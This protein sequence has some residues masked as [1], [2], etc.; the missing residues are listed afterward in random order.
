VLGFTKEES[1]ITLI[2]AGAALFGSLFG[3]MLGLWATYAK[4]AEDKTVQIQ[5]DR[6]RAYTQLKGQQAELLMILQQLMLAHDKG[7]FYQARAAQWM[8]E[9]HKG[10]EKKWTDQTVAIYT[11]NAQEQERSTEHHFD[12]LVACS[13]KMFESI[14]LI[15]LTFP[16]DRTLAERIASVEAIF[17]RLEDIF[18]NE[19]MLERLSRNM[20][21]VH[22]EQAI[23]DQEKQR[24]PY[25][26]KAI[27]PIM[28]LLNYLQSQI[29]IDSR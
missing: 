17:T 13:D 1:R 2:A 26:Q 21:I 14:A 28:D 5:A 19:P 10:Q 18:P 6:R 24:I 22:A 7:D 20:A 8:V 9:D 11:S 15:Q 27:E 29:N 16:A 4:F 12:E 23:N 3:A 25:I